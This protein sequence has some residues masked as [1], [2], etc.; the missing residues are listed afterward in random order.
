MGEW[1]NGVLECW[2]GGVT[3]QANA[4]RRTVTVNAEGRT[5]AHLNEETFSLVTSLNGI[6]NCGSTGSPAKI[7]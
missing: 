7:F 4:E 1:S 3:I 6:R 5:V 2:S